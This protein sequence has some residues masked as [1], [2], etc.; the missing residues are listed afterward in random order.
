VTLVVDPAIGPDGFRALVLRVSQALAAD[1]V[2]RSRVPAG[3]Q[4][5]VVAP[6]HEDGTGVLAFR[7]P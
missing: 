7:R 1:V 5:A 3:L 4:V 2:L 6:G